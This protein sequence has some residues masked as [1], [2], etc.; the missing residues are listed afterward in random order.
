VTYISV[1]IDEKFEGCW[2]ESE[3]NKSEID[4]YIRNKI[5]LTNVDIRSAPPKTTTSITLSIKIGEQDVHI[6][7]TIISNGCEHP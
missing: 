3:I 4:V 7:N 1:G 2:R 5:P 6:H